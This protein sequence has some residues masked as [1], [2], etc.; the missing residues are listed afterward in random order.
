[1]NTLKPLLFIAYYSTTSFRLPSP[2]PV[3][4]ERSCQYGTRWSATGVTRIG[5]A[6]HHQAGATGGPVFARC[7]DE[8]RCE[9]N[10][11]STPPPPPAETRLP[12]R[13]RSQSHHPFWLQWW[14]SIPVAWAFILVAVA[15]EVLLLHS[16][17]HRGMI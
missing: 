7:G 13:Q 12:D 17:R 16:Q 1:M 9:G 15:S 2:E 11:V 3:A 14:I 5:V 6:P 4:M 8:W 10:D